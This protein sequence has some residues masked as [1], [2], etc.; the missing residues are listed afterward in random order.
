MNILSI[1][2]IEKTLND[3]PLF[4]NVTLGLEE[5][6][7]VGIVG[8]N[9][10]GKST[11]LRVLSGDIYPDEGNISTARDSNIVM[12]EQRVD[13]PEG[14][15]VEDFL[16]LSKNK[17]IEK[18]KRYNKALESG[19]ERLYNQLYSEIERENLWDIERAYYALLT[20]MGENIASDRRMDSLSGGQQKKAAIARAIALRP[21]ILLLDEPTNHLDIKTIEYLEAWIKSAK[22][23]VIIVTHDRHILNECCSTIWELDRKVFYRH[24]GNF[25]EYLERKEERLVMDEKEQARLKTILRREL[26]WLMRGPQARTGKDK[27]RKDR[28]YEMQ[29]QLR[30]VRE[31]KQKEFSSL[32]RRLGK[33]ILEVENISKG[34]DGRTLFSG[35]SHSFVKGEK[36][37]LIGDNGCGKSTLLDILSGI[38]LPDEGTV[39]KGVNTQFGYYDQ[40]G[41]NLK[42]GKTVIEF[43][44]DISKRVRYTDGEDVTAARFLEIFG[45]PPSKQR[46]PVE[47]LSGGE[48]RRLY[49]ISR[50]LSNPNFLLFDEPT[51][52]LDLETMENLE[53][54]I[55]SFPGC[56]IISSHDRTFLDITV[57][58][59]FIVENGMITLYPGNYSEWKEEK[60]K[61]ASQRKEVV[62]ENP[63]AKEERPR[64]KKGLSFKETREKETLEKEI[65]ELESLIEDLEASFSS[66]EDG[67]LGSLKERTIKYEESKIALDQ[68]TERWLE[69]EEKA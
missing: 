40:L 27:N 24:P 45:F 26:V 35:F 56:A 30:Q 3:E 59:L 54:Y 15:T 33:K 42:S 44:E 65:E 31:D 19:D 68:K 10:A 63:Q 7:K 2:N 46:T 28:I 62:I 14:T 12:L 57:D 4:E 52:D 61:E 50:L 36:I 47:L 58:M 38:L 22:I 49:L 69:L 37:G 11:F 39:D 34:Y 1:E 55:T 20:D 64:A 67:P 16:Y 48:R 23:A 21:T 6:E 66:V 8:K 41:R 43:A 18:L 53:D 60:E 25:S 51:N 17:N 32:E 9:G 29:S 5:G 13:F